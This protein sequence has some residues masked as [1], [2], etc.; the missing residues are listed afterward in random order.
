MM[1]AI[2]TG[3]DS[4]S[5]E[6]FV[7]PKPY[8]KAVEEE[9]RR[10]ASLPE[11]Q[12]ILRAMDIYEAYRDAK[13]IADAAKIRPSQIVKRVDKMMTK[14]KLKLDS[15]HQMRSYSSSSKASAAEISSDTSNPS[16]ST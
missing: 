12:M 14:W 9:L 3:L 2:L 4:G 13:R 6:H 16:R 10:V 1:L 5:G 8:D 11:E 7:R 15:I